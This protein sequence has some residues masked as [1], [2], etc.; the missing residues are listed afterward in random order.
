MIDVE[1]LTRQIE[2]MML[3]KILW[4][5]MKWKTDS[6]L[7]DLVIF[8]LGTRQISTHHCNCQCNNNW[9]SKIKK[10]HYWNYLAQQPDR[11]SVCLVVE[12]DK[13]WPELDALLAA[14]T[15]GHDHVLEEDRAVAVPPGDARVMP[16][17]GG[18]QGLLGATTTFRRGALPALRQGVMETFLLLLYRL[19]TRMEDVKG[20]RLRIRTAMLPVWIMI[21]HLIPSFRHVL[22]SYWQICT[23]QEGKW[24]WWQ[25]DAMRHKE[26]VFSH[27]LCPVSSLTLP[28]AL[29]HRLV[30]GGSGVIILCH[31]KL[32]NLI[33]L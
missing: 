8:E 7:K 17:G 26:L 11:S 21:T 24:R 32:P 12:V 14:L 9:N 4:E 18:G 30:S 10:D 1:K 28:P 23:D 27:P 29:S 13:L 3:V 33:L 25:E 15:G 22:T 16:G 19:L 31:L 5:T 2:R 20:M 6:C